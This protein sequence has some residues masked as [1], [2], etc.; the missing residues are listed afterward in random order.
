MKIHSIFQVK[1]MATCLIFPSSWNVSTPE[2]CEKVANVFFSATAPGG[3]PAKSVAWTVASR[4]LCSA[5]DTGSMK[6]LDTI[7]TSSKRRRHACSILMLASPKIQQDRLLVMESSLPLPW[8]KLATRS[9]PPP[10]VSC[11][12][13]LTSCLSDFNPS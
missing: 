6:E 9:A 11:R 2:Q 3:A 1:P 5:L 10:G 7:F 13:I 12:L 4:V 8:R